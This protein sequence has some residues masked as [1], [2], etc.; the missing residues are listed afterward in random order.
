MVASK[1]LVMATCPTCR[2]HCDPGAAVCPTD[3]TPLVAGDPR[4]GQVLGDRYRLLA[5]IAEGG[6]G[7]I[8][9]AEHVVLRKRMAVKVLRPELSLDLDL[10]R[11]FQQ[12]AIAAS[13]IGQENIVD[14]T[15][16]G[17]APDGAL[18]F[19]MEELDGVSLATLLHNTGPFPI[20]R[21]VLLLAQICRALAAAHGR[22]IIHRDLKPDNIVVVRRD[23]GSDLAK[24]VDFGISKSG[25][26]RED[27]TM[28]RAGTIIGTPEYMSPEQAAAAI[29]DHRADVYA[30]G[31]VAY[32]ILT[33]TLP[34]HGENAVATLVDHRTK[35]PEPP[36][37]RR[38]GL[39]P[40]LEAMV[41]RAL[42]KDPDA[43]QQSMAEVAVDLTRVL[44]RL[45]LPAVYD[46]A[47]LPPEPLG[48]SAFPG[49]TER[50][51]RASGL[52]P[53]SGAGTLALA[54]PKVTLG[55]SVRR[56]R[57]LGAVALSGLALAFLATIAA[58]LRAGMVVGSAIPDDPGPTGGVSARVDEAAP[59][60]PPAPSDPAPLDPAPPE[61]A[62]HPSE[63]D[64]AE[65]AAA[66]APPAPAK[67]PVFTK[68]QN[69]GRRVSR[70]GRG[71]ILG[72]ARQKDDNPYGALD[73]LKPDPF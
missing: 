10:V 65:P 71:R 45:G 63:P 8:Y 18:Y 62:Q 29:V 44:A 27:G 58:V 34:F 70:A 55:P 67:Q 22:G 20:E 12:E 26:G 5:R 57:I 43:R 9:R 25:V 4:I 33:G 17:R 48:P 13:Q 64:P 53:L 1:A 31:V 56:R 68:G 11:R 32:E 40:E 60:V 47:T 66:P 19:V 50:F 15:D 52:R 69:P 41:L 21:A 24:V 36:G 42:E 39:P 59:D 16:F 72:D 2:R 23:D 14:V 73:D 3:G 37:H 7:T 46:R 51:A 54:P 6:M 28:T 49:M 61:T 30:F 35:A 38:P